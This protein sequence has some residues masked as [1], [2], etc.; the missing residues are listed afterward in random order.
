MINFLIRNRTKEMY[1]IQAYSSKDF[2][3][4]MGQCDSLLYEENVLD[5]MAESYSQPGENQLEKIGFY[6]FEMIGKSD[7]LIR[8]DNKSRYYDKHKKEIDE[9]TEALCTDSDDF[10]NNKRFK[11]EGINKATP[12]LGTTKSRNALGW[13]TYIFVALDLIDSFQNLEKNESNA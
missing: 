3:I 11:I 7:K 4:A 1:N 8:T 9:M 10:E 5:I 13:Q 12:Y 6:F 2:L